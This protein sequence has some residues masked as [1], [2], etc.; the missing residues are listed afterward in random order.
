MVARA[1]LIFVRLDLATS[2]RVPL[3]VSSPRGLLGLSAVLYVAV[4]SNGVL[5]SL[6]QVPSTTERLVTFCPIIKFAT[7]RL[8]PS[9]ARLGIG[10]PGTSPVLAAFLKELP[11][12][13]ERNI[14]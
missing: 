2:N 3:T 5:V 6:L 7:L 1:A 12:Q 8:A 4:V 14:V 9:L 10:A 13:S 11:H